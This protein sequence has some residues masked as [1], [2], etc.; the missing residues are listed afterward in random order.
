MVYLSRCCRCRGMAFSETL[1]SA[2]AAGGRAP[3]T[4]KYGTE[5]DIQSISSFKRWRQNI[6]RVYFLETTPWLAAV[7][8]WCSVLSCWATCTIDRAF[9]NI[10]I[11]GSLISLFFAPLVCQRSTL[12]RGMLVCAVPWVIGWYDIMDAF[13]YVRVH[14]GIVDDWPQSLKFESLFGCGVSILPVVFIVGAA[15]VFVLLFFMNLFSPHFPSNSTTV[16]SQPEVVMVV[17]M[18]LWYDNL[19]VVIVGDAI[20]ILLYVNMWMLRR[21]SSGTSSAILTLYYSSTTVL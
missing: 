15:L 18:I 4:E 21:L 17:M 7:R 13:F 6:K 3:L 8:V 9:E 20:V 10:V 14:D 1:Q 19:V 5:W 12:N 2:H 16:C 11:I